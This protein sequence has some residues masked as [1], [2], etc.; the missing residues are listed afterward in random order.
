MKNTSKILELINAFGELSP[1]EIDNASME[2]YSH[3]EIAEYYKEIGPVDLYIPGHGN[4]YY[5]PSL[6]S[7]KLFQSGYSFDPITNSIIDAW[8]SDWIVL[9]DQGG[10]PF[11]FSKNNKNILFANHGNGLWEPEVIFP[12]IECMV[13]CLLIIGTIISEN[14]EN[15]MDDD[16]N[17]KMESIKLAK[18]KFLEVLENEDIVNNALNLLEWK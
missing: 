14:G 8:N 16:C 15:Y 11:I 3:E 6:K 13:Y 10:D 5:L 2:E 4:D 12:N 17:I 1:Q 9:A 18:R 7:L